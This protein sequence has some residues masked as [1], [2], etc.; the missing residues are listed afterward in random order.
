VISVK[1]CF[2]QRR[3]GAENEIYLYGLECDSAFGF[4]AGFEGDVGFGVECYSG[5]DDV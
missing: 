2:A 5:C 1:I 3:R 4:F